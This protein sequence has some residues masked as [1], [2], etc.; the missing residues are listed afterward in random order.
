[1]KIATNSER[2]AL[3]HNRLTEALCPSSIEIIDESMQHAK[4]KEAM[5]SSGGHYCLNIISENFQNK[6]QIERH[7]MIYSA[8]GDAMDKEIHALSI[9]A[10]APS[11][12]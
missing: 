6:P 11:E 5:L 2:V 12:L 3:M 7:R 1:M 8:L 10:L 9:S 4:H